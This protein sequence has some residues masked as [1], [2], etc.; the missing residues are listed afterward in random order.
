MEFLIGIQGDGF[1][2]VASDMT[3]GRSVFLF[4]HGKNA[5]C[6]RCIFVMFCVL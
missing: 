5:T 6:K 4:K 1:V 2:L 3:A